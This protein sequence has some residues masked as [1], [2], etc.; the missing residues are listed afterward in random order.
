MSGARNS[1]VSSINRLISE[2]VDTEGPAIDVAAARI[3]DSIAAGGVLHVFGSGHSSLLAQEI[4]HRAGGLVPVNAMLDVNLTIFGTARATAV[5]RLEGYAA[6]ILAT[7]DVRPGE[8]VL[9]ISVSG[10]N[11]VPIE[12]A[13]L[14]KE[15]GANVI[16]VMSAAAYAN[17]PSRDRTGRKLSDVADAVLDLHVPWGD[18]VQAIGD[19]G[20]VL[21]ATS[22]VL[23]SVLL[24]CLAVSVA[25]QLAARGESVPAFVSQ[26]IPGGD[27]HNATLIERYR[28]RIPLMKP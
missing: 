23:G 3:A 28:P 15:R 21:G 17:A 10:V 22:T 9:V 16:A 8:V 25:E 11:P 14:A 19:D 12:V 6:S 13:Q 20:M 18:A 26:N 1:Y 24:N 4:F 27:E 5:E 2:L 7:Y